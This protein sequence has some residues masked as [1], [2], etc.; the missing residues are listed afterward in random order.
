[1]RERKKNRYRTV[2]HGLPTQLCVYV[3]ICVCVCACVFSFVY[4]NA[5]E[6]VWKGYGIRKLCQIQIIYVEIPKY[7]A[8]KYNCSLFI[9][10]HFQKNYNLS[11][12]HFPIL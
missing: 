6:Y 7:T 8:Y 12:A 4:L 10:R 1:M 11:F 5:Y 9:F 3:S 2:Q